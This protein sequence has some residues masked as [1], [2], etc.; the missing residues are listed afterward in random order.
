M[1]RP[2]AVYCASL[3]L[4]LAALVVL[5]AQSRPTTSPAKAE[6][7]PA[8]PR[9]AA[10]ALDRTLGDL[11]LESQTLAAVLETLAQR[12][13]IRFDIDDDTYAT[14]PWGRDTRLATLKLSGA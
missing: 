14:L 4:A 3:P 9:P 8:D 7:Q 12:A 13:G 5:S 1:R 10:E 6:S 11:K 2:I